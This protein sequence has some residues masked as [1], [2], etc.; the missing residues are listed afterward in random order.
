MLGQWTGLAATCFWLRNLTSLELEWSAKGAVL[1]PLYMVQ[2]R[3]TIR[4]PH[5][6]QAG[7]IKSRIWLTLQTDEGALPEIALRSLH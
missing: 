5:E 4:V 6:S 7:S 1:V 3:W 2:L